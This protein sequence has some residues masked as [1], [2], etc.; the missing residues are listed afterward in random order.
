MNIFFFFFFFFFLLLFYT[1]GRYEDV[2]FEGRETDYS[3][4]EKDGAQS[5]AD[6]NDDDYCEITNI[7]LDVKRAEYENIPRKLC[8]P[9]SLLHCINVIC[10]H[11]VGWLPVPL[12]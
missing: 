1:Q 9:V 8:T 6:D 3:A 11:V 2:K 5:P 4:L 10:K 7:N 12:V